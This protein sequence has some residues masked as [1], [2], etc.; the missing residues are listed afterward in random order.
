MDN[1]LEQLDT[2][3]K[4]EIKEIKEKYNNLK[5]DVKKKY[6]KDKPKVIRISIPKAVKDKLWDNNFGHDAGIGKCYCCQKEINSK[7]FDCGHIVSVA[8]GGTNNID[9]LKPVCSTCNKSMGN[10]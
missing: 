10:C 1:E 6:K 8:H 2:K 3:M 4:N 5:K 7:K 9:N